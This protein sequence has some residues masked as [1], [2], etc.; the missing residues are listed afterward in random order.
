V[1]LHKAGWQVGK[2]RVQRIWRR[3]GLKVPQKQKPRGR[4]WLNDGSCVRLRPERANHVWAYDFVKAMTH[5]GR[6]LRLLVLIDEY[7]R[8]CLAIQVARRLGNAEVI[9][10][11]A[12]VMLRR[13][14]RRIS[15]RITA[16]SS[17]LRS[18]GSGWG[19]WERER[20]TSS[21]A[22]PGK[23]AT[24]KASMGSCEMNV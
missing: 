20:C 4:L 1:E 22:V 10:V 5:D 23:T 7:T 9:E 3:E 6:A 19:T 24:A 15:A 2:D 16:P 12:E 8:E 17:S 18:C 13:A 21:Q 11:L 14:S